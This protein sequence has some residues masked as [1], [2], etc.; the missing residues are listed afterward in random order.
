[1]VNT[2]GK[3]SKLTF[4]VPVSPEPAIT[5]SHPPPPLNEIDPE[6]VT[7]GN[8]TVPNRL[9][10]QSAPAWMGTEAPPLVCNVAEMVVLA[11][12]V[13]VG[14]VSRENVIPALLL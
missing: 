8:I 13:W 10:T 1:M 12:W 6:G 11:D 2:A 3:L 7:L 5:T 4:V 14:E 9:S